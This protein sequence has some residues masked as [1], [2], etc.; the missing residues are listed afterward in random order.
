MAD[1]YGLIRGSV[2]MLF[3]TAILVACVFAAVLIPWF[4]RLA[5][6]AGTTVQRCLFSRDTGPVSHLPASPITK[7]NKDQSVTLA[8]ARADIKSER[9]NSYLGPRNDYSAPLQAKV[10]LKSEGWIRREDRMTT[11]GRTYKVNRRLK[12]REQN[13]EYVSKPKSWA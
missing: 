3:Y 2:E 5:S 11:G 9:D 8:R 1:R 6:K 12:V 4:F 10:H 13:P 7:T